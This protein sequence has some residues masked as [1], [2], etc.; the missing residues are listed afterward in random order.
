MILLAMGIA[1]CADDEPLPYA[2]FQPT[3]AMEARLDDPA[4][5][6]CVDEASAPYRMSLRAIH[7]CFDAEAERLGALLDR[8]LARTLAASNEDAAIRAD[9]E[10]WEEQIHEQCDEANPYHE[11][12]GWIFDVKGCYLD[13]MKRRILWLDARAD[14][15]RSPTGA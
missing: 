6:A 5:T 2:S 4:F 3:K 14:G 12:W 10:E 8:E 9:Q 11:G 7:A 15:Q 13:E 1:A